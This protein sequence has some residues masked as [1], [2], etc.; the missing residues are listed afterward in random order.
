MP[1]TP[2]AVPPR[3][4]VAIAAHRHFPPE[5]AMPLLLGELVPDDVERVLFLDADL[6][7]LDDPTGLLDVDLGGRALAAAVDGAIALCSGPRGVRAWR[8]QGIPAFAPYFNA[9]VMAISLRDWRE[10]AVGARA[11]RYL[12]TR[13]TSGGGFLHQ[14]ALNAIA[15][16]DWHEVDPRW[17][18]LASHAGRPYWR[19]AAP[20]HAGI[21][22]FAGRMKPWRGGVAG[23][24]AAPYRAALAEV[25]PLLPSSA[26]GAPLR[27]RALGAY[28]RRLRDRLFPLERALW[29]RGLI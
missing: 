21:V 11:L 22:H 12:S 5:A 29:R 1:T 15:W 17:N 24:H 13:G 16:D 4:L 20:A 23:P 19:A 7:V 25:A 27:D 9:G 2:V 18:V 26:D 3:M 10:R 28:D 14:E 6:L 8:E